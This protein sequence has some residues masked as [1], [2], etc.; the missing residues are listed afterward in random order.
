MSFCAAISGDKL[1]GEGLGKLLS[2]ISA[3]SKVV[4]EEET[5]VVAREQEKDAVVTRPASRLSQDFA[6]GDE[7][8][9]ET[10]AA[11]GD[12]GID[13]ELR[14]LEWREE[15]CRE[16][17]VVPRG[18]VAKEGCDE[19]GH[20]GGGGRESGGRGQVDLVGGVGFEVRSPVP[21]ASGEL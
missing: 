8:L 15:F 9:V 21:V 18:G 2:E 17:S 10:I 1:P 3:V 20:I 7:H 6:A 11:A 4:G 19:A 16:D 5:E 12:G 13:F 14:L